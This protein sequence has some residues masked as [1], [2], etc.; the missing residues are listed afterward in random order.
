MLT[1]KASGRTTPAYNVEVLA[2]SPLAYWRAGETSGTTAA[3]SS[4]NSRAGTY[5][6][7]PAMGV[8]GL[9]S[10]DADKAVDLDGVNDRITYSAS[11]LSAGSSI[12]VEAW[13]KM[14]AGGGTVFRVSNTGTGDLCQL[15]L[16]PSNTFRVDFDGGG[17]W[18]TKSLNGSPIAAGT[19]CHVA[20]TWDNATDVARLY[21]N[22]SQ[23]ATD[24]VTGTGPS[25]N[26]ISF[27]SRNGSGGWFDGVVDEFA[28]YG[29]VL[30]GA[31][32]L[33]HYQSGIGL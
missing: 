18:T 30:S 7:S 6:G 14:D 15:E 2:D 13:F 31:R 1:S 9:L 10:G 24:T 25:L 8:T 27:G 3:D 22:G 20:I 17:G 5:A 33:A 23:V 11:F 26:F 29:T 19:T 32:I 28:V 12:T 16:V 21:L 4:G